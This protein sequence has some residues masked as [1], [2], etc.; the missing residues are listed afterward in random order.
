[1]CTALTLTKKNFYLFGRNLD[2][3]VAFGQEIVITPRNYEWKFKF[4][5][6]KVSKYAII[7]M[8]TPFKD[9]KGNIYPLYAEAA[10]EKGLACAGLNFPNNAYYPK[11]G[12]IKDAFEIA[13][14]EIIQWILTSFINVD[15]VITFL[16]NNNLQLVYEPLINNFPIAP[17]HFIVADKN[18]SIVIEPCKE[19]LKWYDNPFGVLTNNPTFDWHMQ[20]INLYQNLV[21]EQKNDVNW[22]N[23]NLTPFGQGFGSFGLPGDS[24]PSSR[25]VRTVFYKAYSECG[26]TLEDLI[27]QFFHILDAVAMVDG[28]VKV[29]NGNND[30]TIYSSCIDLH[31][32]V[33]YYKTHWNNQINVINMYDENLDSNIPIIYPFNKKQNFNYINKK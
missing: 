17:L 4:H 27:T 6:S 14:Y 18:K 16:K 23:H 9:A 15:E 19:G 12:T 21:Q 3:D 1:M 13:P 29:Q 2:L 30:I 8:A 10:N 26:E 33:Y 31:N 28:S 5:Q 32:G 20:N 22:I 25:F 24:T 7:G 11:P